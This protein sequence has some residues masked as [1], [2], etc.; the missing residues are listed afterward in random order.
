MMAVF[1]RLKQ[2]TVPIAELQKNKPNAESL[3]DRLRTKVTLRRPELRHRPNPSAMFQANLMKERKKD[4][5]RASGKIPGTIMTK[6]AAN[7]NGNSG[8]SKQPTLSA[9]DRLKSVLSR[10]KKVRIKRD[11]NY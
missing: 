2:K 10:P 8:N 6:S 9:R 4:Q 11:K 1:N 3:R 7:K 5:I